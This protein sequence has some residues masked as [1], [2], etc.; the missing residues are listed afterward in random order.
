MQT[1]LDLGSVK[2]PIV[3]A[4]REVQEARQVS[5][6][7]TSAIESI[8]PQ[9]S[10]LLWKLM[11]FAVTLNGRNRLPQL[12]PILSIA[13][14]SQ[15]REPLMGMC[16]Q[17]CGPCTHHFSPLASGVARG[18]K[19]IEPTLGHRPICRLRQ[20][21]LTGCLACAINVEDMK[22]VSLPI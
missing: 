18:T 5:E 20:S 3:F 7:G 16:L 15:G 10:L 9:E 14:V 22:V 21:A 12:R 4:P 19:V 17:H 1:D 8:E 11:G 2:D 13:C 6:N